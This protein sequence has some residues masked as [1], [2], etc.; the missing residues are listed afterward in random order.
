[1][2]GKIELG[3]FNDL[4]F[5]KSKEENIP[6]EAAKPRSEKNTTL[7]NFIRKNILFPNSRKILQ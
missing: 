6:M 7:E 2:F 5:K 4:W 3:I 1:L